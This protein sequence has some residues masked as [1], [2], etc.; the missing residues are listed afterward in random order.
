MAIILLQVN[1]L[2]MHKDD[3]Y[4][5]GQKKIKNQTKKKQ[6]KTDYLIRTDAVYLT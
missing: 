5:K 1:Y 6:K 4:T 3:F 2:N